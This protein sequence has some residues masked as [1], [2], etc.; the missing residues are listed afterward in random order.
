MKI[1][2]KAGDAGETGLLGG[3]RIS[4]AD[5]RMEVIGT[6]DELNAS[7]GVC[8][9]CPGPMLVLNTLSWLQS[10]LFDVGSEFACPPDGKFELISVNSADIERLEVEIDEMT[11][12]LPELK[13]FIL[14]GGSPLSA[15]LHIAR[16]VCRRLER[17]LVAFSGQTK[18]RNEPLQFVN[19]L[20]DWIFCSCRLA[21]F[22]SGVADIPWSKREQ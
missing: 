4:K 17:S 14:P 12:V 13:N 6:L 5:L 11:A 2:T 3:N 21:N 16:A 7:L 20:S 22:E 10:L 1:Y 18:V 9:L 15:Q 8:L 19:R